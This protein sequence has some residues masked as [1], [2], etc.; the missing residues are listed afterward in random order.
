MYEQTVLH[1]DL[2]AL[3]AFYKT[4]CNPKMKSGLPLGLNIGDVAASQEPGATFDGYHVTHQEVII[5]KMC[6]CES[7]LQLIA[8]G[9]P[10]EQ[11]GEMAT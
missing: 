7:R 10:L 8:A 5:A 4:C 11:I 2:D 6:G 1:A 3:T 9:E